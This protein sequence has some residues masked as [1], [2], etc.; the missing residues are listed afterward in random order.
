MS[1]RFRI[2]ARVMGSKPFGRASATGRASTVAKI[3]NAIVMKAMKD[4][5]M[6]EVG[7][8]FT[9][10]TRARNRREWIEGLY[11]SRVKKSTKTSDALYSRNSYENIKLHE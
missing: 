9:E 6:T 3:G 7:R 11:C 5:M 4:L 8:F 1:R 2:S 10:C